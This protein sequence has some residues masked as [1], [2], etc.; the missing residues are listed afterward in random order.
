MGKYDDKKEWLGRYLKSKRDLALLEEQYKELI[1][2]QESTGAIEYSDMPKGSG[3]TSD[4][5]NYMIA[6][7]RIEEKYIHLKYKRI[8]I[9]DE[10]LTAINQLPLIE[11]REV[12]TCRYIHGMTWERICIKINRSWTQVVA[13]LHSQALEDLVIPTTAEENNKK[14]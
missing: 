5:S 11:E 7:E 9:G 2:T 12:M 13:R 6:R 4:L 8:T 10:I 1:G 3:N 14:T